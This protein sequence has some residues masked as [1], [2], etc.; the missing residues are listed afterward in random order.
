MEEI[1]PKKN[2]Q[3]LPTE[4]LSPA[5]QFLLERY[6]D[7]AKSALETTAR[8]YRSKIYHE[9]LPKELKPFVKIQTG[10]GLIDAAEIAKILNISK[11]TVHRRAK[12]GLLLSWYTTDLKLRFPKEQIHKKQ[13]IQGIDKVAEII[14]D[15]ELA[16]D[17]LSRKTSFAK[18]FARPLD[19]LKEGRIQEVL[20]TAKSYGTAFT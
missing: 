8:K 1:I 9:S 2:S 12:K 17:F 19:L 14:G 13:I 5:A 11:S 3:A 18:D 16:W 4:D 6:Q 15:P 7:I 20:G 10:E